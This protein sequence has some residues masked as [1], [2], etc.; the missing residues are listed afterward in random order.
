MTGT[1]GC[2]SRCRRP[3]RGRHSPVPLSE[4]PEA[5]RQAII[6]TEDASFYQ[7]PGVDGW[8]IVRAVWIN[9]RGGEVL[10]GGSTITQQ[11]ARNLLLSP[12]ERYERTLTP[13]AARGGPGLAHR[14]R[15][16]PRTRSW[17]CTSTR[18]TSAT[19]PM[20]SRRRPRPTLASMSATW[21][22]PSAPCWPACPRRRPIYNPL[23]NLDRAKARQAVVLDLMVKQGY[24][25][26]DEGA[27]GRRRKSSI[28][29]RP[30]LTS[31][32]PTL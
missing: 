4:M 13:Q 5:L 12:E 11:L 8:A 30:P 6:A 14:A 24:L 23:E 26:A 32:R 15:T 19:W 25:T 28:S 2:S 17:S 20:A 29:P 10:S 1:A 16:T 31:A 7:N 27:A 9:L 3:T 18:S 22:W 21:T